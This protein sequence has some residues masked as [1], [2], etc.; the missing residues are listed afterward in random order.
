MSPYS[1]KL[2]SRVGACIEAQA[3]PQKSPV[4]DQ[5]VTS[6]RGSRQFIQAP[7]LGEFLAPEIVSTVSGQPQ[8]QVFI[9]IILDLNVKIGCAGRTGPGLSVVSLLL[10]RPWL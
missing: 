6:G 1:S 9:S 10:K 4:H 2:D 5:E 3:P 7:G 8:K